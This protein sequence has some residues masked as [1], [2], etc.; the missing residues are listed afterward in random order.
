MN[1]EKQK[2][3]DLLIKALRYAPRIERA[4][5]VG[6]GNFKD[7]W[8]LLN[9]GFKKVDAIDMAKPRFIPHHLDFSFIQ[10]DVEKTDLHQTYDLIN[11]QFVLQSVKKPKELIRKFELALSAQ[12][13]FVG[14]F[15][16][17][18]DSWCANPGVMCYSTE[19]AQ[20]LLDKAFNCLLLEPVID[21]H[22]TMGGQWKNWHTI[23]F[24]VQKK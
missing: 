18:E 6:S 13:V 23:D 1:Y 22:Q 3:S 21:S 14:Q 17:S 9:Y 4:L 8:C 11:A 12:G 7:V 2:P 19:E 24:I 10:Q 16:S 20:G 15:F 5:D